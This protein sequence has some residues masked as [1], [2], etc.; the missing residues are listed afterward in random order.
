[1]HQNYHNMYWSMA[2]T[3]RDISFLFHILQCD[4]NG[5]QRRGRIQTSFPVSIGNIILLL[6][7]GM[8]RVSYVQWNSFNKEKV[9]LI[10]FLK[11]QISK[12]IER[13]KTS[14]EVPAENF[15]NS[16]SNLGPHISSH[17]VFLYHSNAKPFPW[18]E[19][20]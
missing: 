2:K 10:L 20:L 15:F 11:F 9:Q 5:T 7:N 4:F 14:L 3:A 16:P 8:S 17:P 6:W 13:R 1:M 12:T 18:N 19:I